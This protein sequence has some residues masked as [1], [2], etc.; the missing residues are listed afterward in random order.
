M[1]IQEYYQLITELADLEIEATSIA[2]SRRILGELE[3]REE[4]LRDVRLSLKRDIRYLEA[5]FL[6]RKREL[7]FE[8]L[9]KKDSKGVRKLIGRGKS[10][11]KAMKE[12][13]SE[14][15]ETLGSYYELKTMTEELLVEMENAKK[16]LQDFVLDKLG[17]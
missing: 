9:E 14:K 5:E 10:R 16:P 4:I 12:L 17:L 6:K 3:E 2:E 15:E 11:V 7:H 8:H 1:N 13:E